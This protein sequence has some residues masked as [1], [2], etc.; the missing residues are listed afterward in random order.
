MAPSIN[1]PMAS[2]TPGSYLTPQKVRASPSFGSLPSRKRD[3]GSS[4][5]HHADE[6]NKS[7][8]TTPTPIKHANGAAQAAPSPW[9]QADI[10]DL[11]G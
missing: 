10:I 5:M 2:N 4:S 3:F 7:R 8:R 6:P 11:T 9:Q 1:L